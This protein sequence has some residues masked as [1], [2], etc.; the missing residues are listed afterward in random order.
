M[1]DPL[2]IVLADDQ[3]VVRD[4]LCALLTQSGHRVVARVGTCAATLQCIRAL[5]PD[6]CVT[7]NRFSDG[8]AVDTIEVVSQLSPKTKVVMLT[9]QNDTDTMRR[10]L[11]AGVA[12]FVHKSRDAEVLLDVLRRVADGEIVVEGSFLQR[13]REAS[14]ERPSV[15][16]LASFLTHRE[17][18]C[19][20]LLVQGLDTTAMANRL[21]LSRTT[22]RT[23]VQS[24]LTKLGVH[25][26]LEAASVAIRYG[27]LD[28]AG[29]LRPEA[30]GR[31][32]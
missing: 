24:V 11:D 4:A 31:R 8:E 23:H 18:Q 16:R 17:A 5:R 32:W 26:R 29:E 2:D 1:G 25:S 13:R 28:S 20:D 9:G 12:G 7:G 14:L 22:V 6:I 15:R 3:F 30:H 10:A 21:G 19:L 27:L